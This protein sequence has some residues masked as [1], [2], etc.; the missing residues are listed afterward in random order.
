M[1]E[2]EIEGAL[3]TKERK[4]RL[5]ISAVGFAILLLS[6]TQSGAPRELFQP[7]GGSTTEL[8]QLETGFQPG[9]GTRLHFG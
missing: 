4:R 5:P 7:G 2:N 8:N 9:I 6:M 3:C 1:Y